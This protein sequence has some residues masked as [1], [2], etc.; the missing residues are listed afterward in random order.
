MTQIFNHQAVKP[1]VVRPHHAE[2]QTVE[3]DAFVTAWHATQMVDDL[4]T[5]RLCFAFVQFAGEFFVK[6]VDGGLRF[7]PV[8]AAGIELDVRIELRRIVF[9]FDFADDLFQDIFNGDQP[10]QAAEFINH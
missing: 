2:Q 10:G 8:T 6:S 4:A 7:H 1:T 5:N 9:V 3:F